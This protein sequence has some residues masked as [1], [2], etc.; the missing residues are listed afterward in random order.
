[1]KHYFIPY[2][3]LAIPNKLCLNLKQ[4]FTIQL[5]YNNTIHSNHNAINLCFK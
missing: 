1:M 4:Q 2:Y 5:I 3:S